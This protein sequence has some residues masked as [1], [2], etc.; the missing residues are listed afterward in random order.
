MPRLAV[1]SWSSALATTL[2]L[3]NQPVMVIAPLIVGGLGLC[4]LTWCKYLPHESKRLASARSALSAYEPDLAIQTL[5]KKLP[6]EGTH[7]K[8][9][10]AILLSS[11]Y[12]IN[13]MLLEAHRTLTVVTESNLLSAEIAQLNL[14]WAQL[15][16]QAGNPTEAALR[17]AQIDNTTASKDPACLLL[18][19]RIALEQDQPSVARALLETGLENA[20]PSD[21]RVIFLNDIAA[22]D[23]IQG[24]FE[25]QLGHLRAARQLFRTA[26]SAQLTPVLHHNL[27]IALVKAG[28][29]EEA[30]DVLREAWE[31]VNRQSLHQVLEVLNNHL[32]AAREAG[33]TGWKQAAYEEFDRQIDRLGQ[34]TPRTQLALKVSQLR[35]RRNDGFPLTPENY[36]ALVNQL[37]QELAEPSLVIPVTDCIAALYELRH[38]VECELKQTPGRGY[39]TT[40]IAILRETSRQLQGHEHCIDTYLS[41]IPPK[42]TTHIETWYRYQVA[43]DKA[44]VFLAP[45]AEDAKYAFGRLFRRLQEKAEW[46]AERNVSLLTVE[47]WLVLCDEY[48]TYHSQLPPW[49]QNNFRNDF[50]HIALL[51]FEQATRE[52]NTITNLRPHVPQLIGLAYYAIKLR[53]DAAMA[54]KWLLEIKALEPALDHYAIWLRDQY[55][56]TVA[57]CGANRQVA[58]P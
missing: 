26:P 44:A 39:A 6:I 9:Q 56:Q 46:T 18:K 23:G 37:L 15:Y 31:V 43:A 50:A 17:L 34:Q 11:A 42:L 38:D 49:G 47:A 40:L 22:I 52:I 27:A 48:C 30:Q 12:R 14:A 29:T 10:R 21:L 32:H 19:A 20:T 58:E 33:D 1:V 55:F 13:D 54:E 36:I 2:A 51:A 7:Y 45:T 41:A 4:R 16:R 53:N 35:M 3:F 28:K 5:S 24:R 25:A 8:L 57:I